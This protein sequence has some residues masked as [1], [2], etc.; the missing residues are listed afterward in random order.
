MATNVLELHRFDTPADPQAL[1]G[2]VTIRH[3][4]AILPAATCLAREVHAKGLRLMMWHD[5][6]SLAPMVDAQGHPLNAGAFGWDA[7]ELAPWQCREKA[8]RSP[9][10][11]AC[12]VE[13]D[14]FWISREGIRTRWDNPFLATIDLA[15]FEERTGFGAAIVIPVHLPFGQIAAGILT[16]L[17]PAERDLS[18]AFETVADDLATAVRRFLR[19]Y[20][21]VTRDTRYM[22]S[23]SLLSPREIECLSWVAHGKT[24]YEISIILGCS[25]AGVR[26]HVTR[27]C[28]KLGA[29]N[30]AQS[31]FR[32]SQLGF[33]G[34]AA[35]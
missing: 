16:G 7:A 32:A 8:L 2:F 21:T 13:S 31:V 3:R 34:P 6:A 33:L 26:Y 18:E 19:G 4:G 12:R 17:D 20:V 15:D 10:L 23:E 14:P 9:L 30:R 25:H 1:A 27:A 28:E 11:R 22:P 35:N 5:L 29:V 24:D